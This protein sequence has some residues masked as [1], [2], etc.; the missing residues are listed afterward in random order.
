MDIFIV[1]LFVTIVLLTDFIPYRKEGS[2]RENVLY[3]TLLG[4]GMCVLLLHVLG[5]KVP[6][7]A[8]PIQKLVEAVFGPQS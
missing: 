8:E 4:I 3:L 7:P 1:L 6:S 5:V 2:K